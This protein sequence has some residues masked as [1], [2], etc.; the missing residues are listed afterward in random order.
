MHIDTGSSDLWVNTPDSRICSSSSDPCG[1]SGTFN[2]KKSKTLK[3][4]SSDFNITYADG[5]GASGDY[6]T[7][8][9]K[10]G[11]VTLKKFQFATGL[12]S[13]SPGTDSYT[14]KLAY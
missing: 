13:T 9:I 1:Q 14:L 4:V 3:R 2:P 11:G 8:T 12:K 5:T 7:D 6:V 10:V